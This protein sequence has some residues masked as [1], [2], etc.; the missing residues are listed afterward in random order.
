MSLGNL[1]PRPSRPGVEV[2]RAGILKVHDL[3]SRDPGGVGGPNCT[4]FVG[5]LTALQHMETDFEKFISVGQKSTW[6][7][8]GLEPF[9]A[10]AQMPK[11]RAKP[12]SGASLQEFGTQWLLG[13]TQGGTR[14][15]WCMHYQILLVMHWH[16]V[17][18]YP[19]GLCALRML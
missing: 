11:A 6:R 1:G 8:M 18:F 10:C 5:I 13:G 9:P 3:I 17:A 2:N 14:F 16:L 19:N 4:R 15:I 7:K 12:A